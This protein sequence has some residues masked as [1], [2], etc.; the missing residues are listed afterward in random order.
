MGG[1]SVEAAAAIVVA[2]A[3][4]AVSEEALVASI[5]FADAASVLLPDA[6]SRVAAS[7]DSL[8]ASPFVGTWPFSCVP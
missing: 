4:K 1:G 5:G 3:T 2:V 6:C 8:A 7:S